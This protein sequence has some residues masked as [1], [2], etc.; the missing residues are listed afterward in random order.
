ME[1]RAPLSAKPD[2]CRQEMGGTT[3]ACANVKECACTVE[4]CP[5]HAKC[6]EC[7]AYHRDHEGGVPGCFFTKQGE[8]LHDRSFEALLKDRGVS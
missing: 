6:C 7:V 4:G 2:G 5:R 1:N 8:A 3:M